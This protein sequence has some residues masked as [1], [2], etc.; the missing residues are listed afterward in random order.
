MVRPQVALIQ[1]RILRPIQGEPYRER[2][3][4]PHRRQVERDEGPV[5]EGLGVAPALLVLL[6]GLVGPR[7][8]PPVAVGQEELPVHDGAVGRVVLE[9]GRARRLIEEDAE[10]LHADHRVP[11]EEPVAGEHDVAALRV[12]AELEALE[13]VR[14]AR[15]EPERDGL[16]GLLFVVVVFLVLRRPLEDVLRNGFWFG[17]QVG[18]ALAGDGGSGD[19][20]A[21]DVRRRDGV[22]GRGIVDAGGNL[23]LL[24]HR[25]KMC[26]SRRPPLQVF[27]NR[28]AGGSRSLV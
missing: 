23:V 16:G 11:F 12:A 20:E 1:L 8:R 10:V 4:A 21:D 2:Q 9:H 17:G 25:G 13:R 5:L 19:E 18:Y 28:N 3:H 22:P 26:L 14:Q 27:G 15:G 24:R 6:H 7:Q